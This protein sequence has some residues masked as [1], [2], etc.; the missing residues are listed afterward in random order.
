MGYGLRGERSY[1]YLH[2]RLG[3]AIDCFNSRDP[4][5]GDFKEPLTL[6]KYLY[7]MND[8][9]NLIDPAGLVPWPYYGPSHHWKPTETWELIQ[10]EV[11]PFV[12]ERGHIDGPLA[13]FAWRGGGLRVMSTEDTQLFKN[14]K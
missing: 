1:F 10:E 5:T 14:G 3:S 4:V 8:P 12:Q 6:H 7:C 2:G 11:I 9:V 13:A